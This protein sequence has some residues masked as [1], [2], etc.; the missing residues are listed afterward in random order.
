[1]LALFINTPRGEAK[2]ILGKEK[3]F[4]P[5]LR[6][7]GGVFDAT[8]FSPSVLLEAAGAQALFG[9]EVVFFFDNVLKDYGGEVFAALDNLASSPNLIVFL[10]EDDAAEDEFKK[11][12][13]FISKKIVAK[14]TQFENKDIFKLSDA[15]LARDKKQ[16][17]LVFQRLL[18]S[19]E[20]LNMAFNLSWAARSI[21]IARAHTLPESKLSPFVYRKAKKASELYSVDDAADILKA[22]VS[23]VNTA[24]WDEDAA[25]KIE[26]LILTRV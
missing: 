6:Q 23:I 5:A 2:K 10:E 4:A 9:G 11:H 15:F 20:P 22:L 17:W 13:A 12:K 7:E 16:A 26:H 25:E 1:M 14:E 3:T 8:D 19:T 24:A 18:P 21:E